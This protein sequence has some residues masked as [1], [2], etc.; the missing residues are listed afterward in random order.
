MY[1]RPEKII[2]THRKI[3]LFTMKIHRIQKVRPFALSEPFDIF[4]KI[5]KLGAFSA[6]YNQLAD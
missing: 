4:C 6:T 2:T 5:Y 1:V 3:H